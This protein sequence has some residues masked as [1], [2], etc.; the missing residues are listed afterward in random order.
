MSDRH[1]DYPNPILRRE[2]EQHFWDWLAE[3]G[4]ERGITAHGYY[5][6]LDR[7]LEPWPKL[8]RASKRTIF[9]VKP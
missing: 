8:R 7:G 1:V 6:R 9:V 3:K 2:G 5:M 4:A